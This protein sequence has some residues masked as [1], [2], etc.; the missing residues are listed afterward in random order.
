MGR[1]TDLAQWRGATVNSGDG[2]GKTG[3]AA[4]RLAEHR[5]VIIH[6]AEGYFEGTISWQKNPSA[7]VSSHFVVAKDGR[8]AQVVDTAERAWTQRT[9]NSS[10]LSIE[11]EGF[12]PGAL[13]PAQVTAN[14][15]ILARAHREH[16]I[17]LQ[18]ANS[19]A[20]RGLGHHSMG[21]ESGYD[22]GHSQC[23]GPAIKAQKAEILRQAVALVG[24]GQTT[25][26]EED[27]MA[28]L[29]ATEQ[30][31]VYTWL[32]DISYLLWQG[33]QRRDGGGRTDVRE[34]F[35][36]I[37]D[38]LAVIVANLGDGVDESAILARIDQQAREI[39]SGVVADIMAR[40]PQQ[41]PVDRD[42]LVAALTTVLGSV[43]GATPTGG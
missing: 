13:T 40:L 42:D 14:A 38:K 26:D 11:N 24:D 28:E 39:R 4:D 15:K 19:P 34:E 17:P 12:I 10:W 32:K 33:A 2:D 43:D 6:I 1:W 18:L 25:D 7:D 30:R 3:E 22:W 36:K 41:G 16:G 35:Y 21:A 31:Q 29:S 23:P 8:I 9:G 5:G 27:F 37:H 20:G